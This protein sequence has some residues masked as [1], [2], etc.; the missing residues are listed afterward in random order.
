MECLER[1]TFE[2]DAD[3]VRWIEKVVEEYPVLIFLPS[4]IRGHLVTTPGAMKHL[5]AKRH[6]RKMLEEQAYVF[7][8]YV[9]KADGFCLET[10][11]QEAGIRH[12]ILEILNPSKRIA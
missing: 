11:F 10:A 6:R 5:P 3:L 1:C 2:E 4:H 7:Y 12:Q 9:G 8:L